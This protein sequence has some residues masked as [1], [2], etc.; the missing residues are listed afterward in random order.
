MLKKIIYLLAVPILF[1]F[2]AAAWAQQYTF[3]NFTT[4]NGLPVTQ[5]LSLFQND[6]AVL[7]IGTSNGGI[8]KYNGVSFEYLTDKNGLPDNIVYDINKNAKGEILI[9]TSNGLA[10]YKEGKFKKYTTANGLSHNRIM[11]IFLDQRKNT[12]LGTAQ[13]VYLMEDTLFHLFDKDSLLSTS[14][15]FNIYEDSQHHFWF[16][17]ATNGLYRY[18]G[19]KITNYNTLNGLGHNLVYN[20]LEVSAQTYWILTHKGVY[21]LSSTGEIAKMELGAWGL[22]DVPC[23][24]IAKDAKNTIWIG[25]REGV[26]KYTPKGFQLYKDKNGLVNNDIWKIIEDREGNMWFAS[27]SNGISKLSNERFK[28]YTTK[29]GLT[30]NIVTS[31]YQTKT[32]NFWAGTANGLAHLDKDTFYTYHTQD[33]LSDNNMLSIAEDK[34]G[35]L[36]IGAGRGLN[37]YNGKSFT[38]YHSSENENLNQCHTILVDENNEIWLGTKGGIA[39]VIDGDIKYVGANIITFDVFDIYQDKQGLY[40][41][42]TENGL[43][44]FNGSTYKHFTQQDQITEKRVRSIVQDSQ[45]SLWF[46]SNSGI[47]R[48]TNGKFT[49]YTTENGLLSNTV[50]SLAIDS[51]GRL[52]AGMASGID[53]IEMDGAKIVRIRHYEQADGFIGQDCYLN[54]IWADKEGK[55][56]I[57]T[58]KGLVIYQPENEKVNTLEPIIQMIGVYLNAQPTRWKDLVDSVS[59]NN[60]PIQLSLPYDQHYLSFHFVGTSLTA[61]SKVR[62]QYML[63]GLDTDWLPITDKT[64]AVYPS[65]P[66][67]E[68]EFLVKAEN[69]EGVWNQQPVSFKFE[70][71]PPFWRTWWFYSICFLI[72][73]SGVFSYLQIRAANIKIKAANKEILAQ[74]NIIEEKNIELENANIEIAKKNKDITD[75]INYAKRIQE[76]ILPPDKLVKEYIQ[77]SFILYKP[78]DIV[79]GD[80]Y[81]MG[82]KDKKVLF[83]VGDCTGHGVPGALMSIVGYNGLNA[84]LKEHNLTLPGEILDQLNEEVEE[85]FSQ[86]E[87]EIKDGMDIA[88]CCIDYQQQLLHFAGAYNPMYL[89]RTREISLIELNAEPMKPSMNAGPF[90][91]YEIKADRQPIGAFEDRK[92]FNT[93]TFQLQK[94]DSL[95]IFSDGYA[96]QFGGPQKKKFMYSQLKN[97]LLSIQHQSMENQRN[98]LNQAFEKWK[99]NYEQ[100]DDVC[101]IGIRI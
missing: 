24:A 32:E 49:N 73:A 25:T 20:I 43:Y 84:A 8:A 52:W 60:L 99:G 69:G 50:Y 26:M 65:I 31:I 59:V 85:T 74:A 47:Y 86:Q 87:H 17:T 66:P 3:E 89:V 12:W 95:Y 18:D 54:A 23:Y 51:M 2:H 75:S 61:P 10:V 15:I 37:S 30:T 83:A 97:L 77:N 72:F 14:S 58:P 21:A 1:L 35:I 79:S 36:W 45:G 56:W 53:K 81:W 34:N 39:K 93:H 100:V 41:L 62:Y 67:G 42:A 55:I 33:G 76:A 98:A 4:E 48:Y 101:I 13:G 63:K 29:N 96:D 57:G 5:I 22:R 92:K 11:K 82:H 19:N 91:L 38:Q 88:I 68:Y 64:E 6:D 44:T 16:C 90:A 27:K 71:K 28:Y 9:G 80:F 7:W 40:W 94:G 46:S 78:K 70:I